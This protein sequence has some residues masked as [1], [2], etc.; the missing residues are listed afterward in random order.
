MNETALAIAFLSMY[1]KPAQCTRVQDIA[2]PD[3]ALPHT[4]G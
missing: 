4:I 1:G 3:K 2:V